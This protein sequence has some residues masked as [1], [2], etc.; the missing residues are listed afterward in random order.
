M[1]CE[2]PLQR[3]PTPLG[4]GSGSRSGWTPFTKSASSLDDS[5]SRPADGDDPFGLC[6]FTPTHSLFIGLDS[7]D[8][9]FGGSAGAGGY[10]T[11]TPPM[12]GDLSLSRQGRFASSPAG[13]GAA[14]ASG[15][16]PPKLGQLFPNASASGGTGGT[17]RRSKPPVP[18]KGGSEEYKGFDLDQSSSKQR[19]PSAG[20]S[21]HQQVSFFH[22]FALCKPLIYASASDAGSLAIFGRCAVSFGE[23]PI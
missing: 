3:M 18:P 15:G 17:S 10:W 6:R 22:D 9:S 4:S 16:G 8:G 1:T 2:S 20:S 11:P 23:F 7:G 14:E 12:G 19:D 13:A 21:N 5:N